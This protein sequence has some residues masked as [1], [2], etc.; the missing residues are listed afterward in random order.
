MKENLV[1]EWIRAWEGDHIESIPYMHIYLQIIFISR[2]RRHMGYIIFKTFCLN[3]WYHVHSS[4]SSSS[5][6]IIMAIS[7]FWLLLPIWVSM[8]YFN[9]KLKIEIVNSELCSKYML[10]TLVILYT[11]WSKFCKVVLSL[12]YI[13]ILFEKNNMNSFCF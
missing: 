8:V 6:G 3:I 10:C 7:Q 13:F 12:L 1:F 5:F 9:H 11:T 4:S 2:L